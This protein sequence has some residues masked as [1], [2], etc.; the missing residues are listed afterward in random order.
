[1]SKRGNEKHKVKTSLTHKKVV[2]VW[3]RPANTE[4]LHE[5]VKLAMDVAANRYRAFLDAT[6]DVGWV[7]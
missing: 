6:L 7:L 2:C 3:I 4:K 5:I 1:M